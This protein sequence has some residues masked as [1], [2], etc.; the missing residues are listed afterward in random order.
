MAE[1]AIYKLPRLSAPVAL[2]IVADF[3][4]VTGTE[5]IERIGVEAVRDGEVT[6]SFCSDHSRLGE[7]IDEG[8][9]GAL[10]ACYNRH[11]SCIQKGSRLPDDLI[12]IWIDER[13]AE[14]V[15]KMLFGLVGLAIASIQSRVFFTPQPDAIETVSP[16]AECVYLFGVV[17]E[18]S[19]VA[20]AFA[21]IE[22]RS[23]G[24]TLSCLGADPQSSGQAS[25]T[26]AVAKI[27]ISPE[28]GGAEDIAL[29]HHEL[30]ESN[31]DIRLA[32]PLAG[33]HL[34]LLKQS[35]LLD[36]EVR[37]AAGILMTCLCRYQHNNAPVGLAVDWQRGEQGFISV[38]ALE[39]DLPKQDVLSSVGAASAEIDAGIYEGVLPDGAL[40]EAQTPPLEFGF[41]KLAALEDATSHLR[42]MMKQHA[43]VIGHRLSLQRLPNYH[44]SNEALLE[45]DQQI[46]ELSIRRD[47]ILG[48]GAGDWRLLRI[49]AEGLDAFV[50]Y[51]RRFSLEVI[52][53]GKLQYAFR[54]SSNDPQG[55]H[56]LL[57]RLRDVGIEPAYP[58]VL[59]EER[60]DC[61]TIVHR[62][63]PMFAQFTVSH[64]AH[65]L[66]FTPPAHVVVPG[67]RATQTDMDSYLKQGFGGLFDEAILA[68]VQ[69]MQSPVYCFGQTKDG[70]I[71]IEVLD[72]ARFMPIRRVIP[73]LNDNLEIGHYLDTE[74]FVS[75]VTDLSWRRETM[76]KLEIANRELS[77]RM[78]A[79]MAQLDRQLAAQ[80]EQLLGAMA[81]EVNAL[82]MYLS[83]ITGLMED[84]SDRSVA[85][86]Q[87]VGKSI[88]NAASY[89]DM[90]QK[91]PDKFS[92]LENARRTI[93]DAI[94]SEHQNSQAFVAT[95]NRNI[96]DMRDMIGQLMRE[97]KKHD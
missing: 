95:A 35:V 61:G 84:L 57:Y 21:R 78:S 93:Q 20:E 46:D 49:P 41:V 15:S 54:G 74:D 45:I 50:D 7:E 92:E 66:V 59:W 28:W 6:L 36:K 91:I 10:F 5:M 88:R 71:R 2:A 1:F 68:D 38:D 39:I 67:F 82:R 75:Q 47:L 16:L 27:G 13:P 12:D 62:V 65:S 18:V 97:I 96:K 90:A 26:L 29:K 83:K 22:W 30:F 3:L 53:S 34:L 9:E 56:Y 31:V 79:D 85:L 63:D 24:M 48:E 19:V 55:V 32:Y 44:D 23:N 52:D 37:D 25:G 70:K 14:A 87:L 81:E 8:R 11:P 80:S 77:S 60:F 73:F 72:G 64:K 33:G 43:S 51:L 40:A 4:S 86:E 89:E 17:E 42:A 69:S 58:A 76:Q 94:W